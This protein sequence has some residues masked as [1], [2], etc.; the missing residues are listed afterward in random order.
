MRLCDME[1]HLQGIRG[2]RCRGPC[3]AHA[4]LLLLLLLLLPPL[5][6]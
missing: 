1:P 6:L 5:L 4:S 3:G 2:G